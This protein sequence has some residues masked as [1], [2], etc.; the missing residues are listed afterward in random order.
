MNLIDVL[1]A[2]IAGGVEAGSSTGQSTDQTV[3]VTG[4]S[5]AFAAVNNTLYICSSGLTALTVSS[6][7]ASG[8]FEIVFAS[9][10]TA[11]ELT[12]PANIILPNHVNIETDT[13]YELSVRVLSV[14]G[15][16]VGMAALQGW[17]LQ[18]VSNNAEQS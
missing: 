14:D 17:P 4:T 12:L 5:P 2:R 3:V 1:I 10:S 6:L 15:Q 16:T 11:P 8:L 13:V 9:G 18:E 7:P